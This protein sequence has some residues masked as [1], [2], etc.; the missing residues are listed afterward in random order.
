MTIDNLYSRCT[1]N[2]KIHHHKNKVPLPANKVDDLNA[3]K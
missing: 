1:T 3:R 2:A